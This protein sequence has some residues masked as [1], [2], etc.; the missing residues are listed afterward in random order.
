MLHC[1]MGNLL[2][3]RRAP[4]APESWLVLWSNRATRTVRMFVGITNTPRDYAW[5]S[6]VAI[7]DLLGTKPS[8]GP[9]AELWL[10]TH[11]GSPSV[12]TH[13][14][15]GTSATTLADLTTLPFLLKVLAA[16]APL[17]LQAH[18]TLEQAAAGFARENAAGVPLDASFR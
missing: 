10:G 7:A 3:V 16:D 17:S 18:P 6:R 11:P 5:G 1:L 8:G 15:P 4:S 9:E 14:A 13:L 12:L 2:Q